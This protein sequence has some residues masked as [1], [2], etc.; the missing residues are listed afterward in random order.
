[1]NRIESSPNSNHSGRE[2]PIPKTN[3]NRKQISSKKY[4][5]DSGKMT[6]SENSSRKQSNKTMNKKEDI[7]GSN[8][9]NSDFDENMQDEEK[10]S[11]K[12]NERS[13]CYSED[14]REETKQVSCDNL[15]EKTGKIV[16]SVSI[17]ILL[18][19]I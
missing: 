8:S 4:S 16:K 2:S 14:D 13:I 12:K 9:E 11:F 18:T 19:K 17:L 10:P 5:E 6:I 1:M 3:F 7:D 15:K